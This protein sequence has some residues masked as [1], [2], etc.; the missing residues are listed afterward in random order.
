MD[1]CR[2]ITP[3]I[4][5]SRHHTRLLLH[6]ALVL[7]VL[8]SSPHQII[9]STHAIFELLTSLKRIPLKTFFSVSVFAYVVSLSFRSA[10]QWISVSFEAWHALSGLFGDSAGEPA[11]FQPAS[12]FCLPAPSFFGIFCK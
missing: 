4:S 10:L 9:T 5:L 6:R 3:E 8:H 1:A 2:S 12:L 11:F 7:L